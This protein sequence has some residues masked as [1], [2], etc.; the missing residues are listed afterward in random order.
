MVILLLNKMINI[1]KKLLFDIT[2]LILHT[3]PYCLWDDTENMLRENTNLT[4]V[5]FTET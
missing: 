3:L 2:S 1:S 5:Y 4:Q